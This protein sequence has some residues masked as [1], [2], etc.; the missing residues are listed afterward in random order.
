MCVGSD[1]RLIAAAAGAET[2]QAQAKVGR[3]EPR[4]AAA[5]ARAITLIDHIRGDVREPVLQ[6]SREVSGIAPCHPG[7][8]LS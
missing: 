5:A 6:H 7:R 1:D 8:R 3:W 4:C 2:S